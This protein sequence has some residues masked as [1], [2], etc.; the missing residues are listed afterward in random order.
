MTRQPRIERLAL[1]QRGVGCESGMLW[2]GFGHG[3]PLGFVTGELERLVGE[4]GVGQRHRFY[5]IAIPA[6]SLGS[7]VYGAM[8]SVSAPAGL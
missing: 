8:A 5:V 4:R 6:S 1:G 2:R 7:S 3:V